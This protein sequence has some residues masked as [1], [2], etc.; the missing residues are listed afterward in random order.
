VVLKGDTIKFLP[1][2][3]IK[4]L[5]LL[6]LIAANI[7]SQAQ[8]AYDMMVDGVKVIV[9][10]GNNDIVQVLTVIK[11]GVQN[12]PL[13]K[14]GIENLAITSL[15]EG[16]TLNDD[17]NSFKNKL[18][19]V[20]AYIGGYAGMDF[21]QINLNCILGDFETVW[22]LYADAIVK[23]KFDAKEFDRVKQDALNAVRS[24]Q[25]Q[26]DYAIDQLAKQMAFGGKDYAKNPDGT[27]ATL[28]KLTLAET[29]AYYQSVLTK[30]RLLIVVVGDVEKSNIEQKIKALLA[31]VPQGKPFIQQKTSYKPPVN[32]FKS[33]KK[34]FATNYIH[35]ISGA[36]TP[37]SPDFNAFMVAMRI[38][39]ARHFV[40][41]RTK[42][43]LSYA[44]GAYMSGS[45]TA[46]SNITV[47][48][49]KPDDYIKVAKDLIAKTQKEGFTEDEVKNMKIQYGTQFFYQQ[50]TN[51]ALAS[52][53]ASNEVLHGNWKRSQTLTDDLKNL[54]IEDVNKAF[55]KY[56]T[57][58][59][60]AYGGD[61]SK[62]NPTLY[63]G[64]SAKD[65]LPKKAVIVEKKG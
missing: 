49:T 54:S 40:D 4:F 3:I 44:P 7:K 31:N 56:F 41:V 24:N 38:F 13:A 15:T 51:G 65:S 27:I 19:K 63:T 26:P 50:E 58:I 10:P 30:S 64:K 25:S 21:A 2:R 52:S 20:A 23:P 17:K 9:K 60:W 32:S 35:G 6:L 61:P 14:Q 8:E 47:S 45:T 57:N 53:L 46:S 12:Y 18:D 42:N 33:E 34:D 28:E 36:P 11:G 43:G 62:V 55:N 22:P 5:P 39:S 29:K 1:M 37:G 48:T 59:T 16:G